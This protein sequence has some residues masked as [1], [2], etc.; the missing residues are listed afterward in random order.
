MTVWITAPAAALIAFPLL[1]A[2]PAQARM[3]SLQGDDDQGFVQRLLGEKASLTLGA[4]LAVK[5]AY[6]GSDEIS[7]SP[8]P[9]LALDGLARGHLSVSFPQGV[10]VEA[11]PDGPFQLGANVSYDFGR[12]TDDIDRLDGMDDIDGAA[13]VKAFVGYRLTHFSTTATFLHRFGDDSG[14][15]VTLDAAVMARPLPSLRLSAGP[16]VTWADK[17]YTD[18]FFG[19]SSTEAARANARGNGLTAYE[20]DAGIKDVDLSLTAVYTPF[21]HWMIT[22]KVGTSFLLGDAADSPL[23]EATVQPMTYVGVSYRF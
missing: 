16:S 18:A 19:V 4:G 22:G 14:N 3:P 10:T 12:S 13:E 2:S 11:F 21:E 6:E 1:F 8:V 15:L 5:P 23:T 7:F 17:D 9:M 20:A